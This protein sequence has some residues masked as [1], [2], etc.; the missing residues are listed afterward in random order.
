[1]VWGS[2]WCRMRPIPCPPASPGLGKL[3]EVGLSSFLQ[4]PALGEVLTRCLLQHGITRQELDKV[5]PVD[6]EQVFQILPLCCR[7]GR[8]HPWVE[9]EGF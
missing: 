2:C 3:L 5:V 7:Q 8:V 9:V 4:L 1:M 6:P